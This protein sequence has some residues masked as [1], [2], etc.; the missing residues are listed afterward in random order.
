[1]GTPIPKARSFLLLILEK[2]HREK[3]EKPNFPPVFVRQ[4]SLGVKPHPLVTLTLVIIVLTVVVGARFYDR[5][6][7]SQGTVSGEKINAPQDGEFIDWQTTEARRDSIRRGR[8]PILKQDSTITEQIQGEVVQFINQVEQVRQIAGSFPFLHSNIISISTQ[9]Y[10]R[11]SS[12]SSWQAILTAVENEN[13][14][15]L[16]EV[17]PEQVDFAPEQVDFA[18]QQAYWGTAYLSSASLGGGI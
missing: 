16:L 15:W 6:Q 9:I 13:Y 11:Q 17:E 7:L 8:I 3:M 2:N 1:M 10:L 14:N 5:P 4:E 18:L 12:D